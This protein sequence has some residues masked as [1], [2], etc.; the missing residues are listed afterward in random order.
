[1]STRILVVDDHQLVRHGLRLTLSTRPDLTV[2][3]EA[4]SVEQAWLL[5]EQLKPNLVLLDLDLPGGS[6]IELAR[7][8]QL[9]RLTIKTLILTAH[10]DACRVQE[11]LQ[12]GV[13][14][15][16]LKLNAATELMAAISTIQAGGIHLSDEVVSVI[17]HGQRAPHQLKDDRDAQALSPREHETLRRIAEGETIKEI[18]FELGVSA[19]TVESHRLNLMAKL[20]IRSVAG[21]TKHA[22]RTGITPLDLASTKN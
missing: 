6:G 10:I 16:M 20:G 22:V 19:R 13:A 2:V 4:G 7:R 3:G 14:G 9:N 15:Y 21:L 8:I 5:I 18:A 12:A 17:A 1:M 11:A